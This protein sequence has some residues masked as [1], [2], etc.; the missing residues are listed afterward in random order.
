MKKQELSARWLTPPTGGALPSI[1]DL[2]RQE[3]SVSV[4][5]SP[6]GLLHGLADFRGLPLT[7]LRRLRSLQIRG[8]DLSG[9]NLA[10]L[11]IE[12]CVFEN[13]N[14]EQ[15]D[16]TN[17]GD[18]GNA[19]EDCRFLRASFGAAVLG[20]SG[21]RYNGCLFDRTR[22]AR[23]LLVRP[24]FSG[25]RFLDCHLKNIDFNGSSFDHCAFAG[26]LDDVWFRG[27]FPLPVDTEKYGAARPNTMTGVSFCDASLSGIT[28]SDR[29]DLS[30]IVL[31]REGH[32]RLYS[33][34]KKRLEGL[35]KVIEAWPDSERRE[36]DIFVAAYMVH[37][38]KQEWYLVNCDEIIQEYRGSVGRK[39]I[40]GLGAPD[41]VS[42]QVN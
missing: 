27:G 8:I 18:F 17:V 6:F 33:G 28:F 7:E 39:I 16:L 23:T 31:P 26:R 5:D 21:T 15:A 41:R 1:L 3:G 36:A 30:T 40:D 13:V 34:W 25:C 38:A 10:R 20:Y 32:Y 24:E 11:N 4:G 12:N 9:A 29:C 14:F 35:E 37:A 19:F 2:F 22:F 42:P